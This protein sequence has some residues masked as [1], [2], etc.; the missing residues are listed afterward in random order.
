[1]DRQTNANENIIFQQLRWCAVEILTIDVQTMDDLPDFIFF[2][3]LAETF[4]TRTQF[5][6]AD[7]ST[8]VFVEQGEYFSKLCKLFS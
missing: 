4:E 7:K 8:F 1:M 2:R 3:I 6:S 5:L